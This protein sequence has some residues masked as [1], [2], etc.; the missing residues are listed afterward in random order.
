MGVFI[1]KGAAWFPLTYSCNR[2]H[3]DDAS[4]EEALCGAGHMPPE[5]ENC[6]AEPQA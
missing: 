6:A 2:E 1:P 3:D 4:E 5:D